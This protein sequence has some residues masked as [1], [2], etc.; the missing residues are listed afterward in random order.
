MVVIGSQWG[1]EGKGKIIDAMASQSHGV[2][3][4]QGGANAGHTIL[5]DG[6]KT[7]LHLIPSGVLHSHVRCFIGNG[8]AMDPFGMFQEIQTL[9]Q[10]G[11]LGD[12]SQISI[13]DG[14]LLVLP[15]HCQLDQARESETGDRKLGTT[16]RGIG[17][18]YEDRASRRALLF[19]DLFSSNL[20]DQLSQC[21][22]E[23]N[24]LLEKLYGQKPVDADAIHGKLLEVAETLRPYR[25]Q[26]VSFE[27]T[28]MIQ[29]G[30]RVLFEGAQGVLLDNCHGTFPFVTS[31]Q[32]GA[33]A[34]F[35]GVGLNSGFFTD[36]IFGITRLIAQGWDRVLFPRSK[37]TKRG[38]FCKPRATSLEPPQVAD[39][40][41]AGWIW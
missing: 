16:G 3:R 12:D 33:S 11:Y 27:V 35:G 19:R 21:L 30:K 41:V 8:V 4:F 22:K 25:C 5:I 39:V 20:K 29:S 23:K 32:T 13:S 14:T 38:R 26:N 18:S 24:F 10:K 40:V 37:K 34:A 15:F 28:K 1:D 36:N 31:S 17:P 9:K 6:E 7:I 2:V